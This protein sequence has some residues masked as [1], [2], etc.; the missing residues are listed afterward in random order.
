M[1]GRRNAYALPHL[2]AF[3]KMSPDAVIIQACIALEACHAPREAA[4]PPELSPLERRNA[5]LIALGIGAALFAIL[6]VTL[7]VIKAAGY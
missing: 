6:L 2:E 3:K 4:L 5:K 7:T 1:W